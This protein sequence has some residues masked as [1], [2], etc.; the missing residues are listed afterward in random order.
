MKKVLNIKVDTKSNLSKCHASINSRI[1][2]YM[3]IN[4]C[5][6]NPIQQKNKQIAAKY[7]NVKGK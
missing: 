6:W 1:C 3:V 2:K 5:K 4:D 7:H